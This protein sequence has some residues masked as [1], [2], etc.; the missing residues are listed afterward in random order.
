MQ[1]S[2]IGVHIA[3]II[4]NRKLGLKVDDGRELLQAILVWE[5][6]FEDDGYANA[7]PAKGDGRT[8]SS[9]F[10]IRKRRNLAVF[11]AERTWPWHYMTV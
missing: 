5:C 7:V 4:Q 1:G 8:A 10:C 3:T 6:L 2:D 11:R 9:T